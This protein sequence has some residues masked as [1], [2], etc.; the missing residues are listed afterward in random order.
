MKQIT[1]QSDQSARILIGQLQDGIFVIENEKMAFVNQAFAN[2]LSYEVNELIGRPFIELV[3]PED[4]ILIMERYLSRLAGEYVPAQYEIR[5]LTSQGSVIFCSL[6]IGLRSDES[7]QIS[8]IG[9]IRDV[10]LLKAEIAKLE[11]TK[12]DLESIFEQLPD[13][14]YRTNMQG[15]ITLISP[16]CFE[17]LGYRQEVM[18]GTLMADYYKTPEE[19]QKIVKAITDGKGKA[20]KVEAAFKHKDDSI[21]WISTSAAVRLDADNNPIFIE[22]VA[23]DISDRKR[24]EDQLTMLSRIDGLTGVYSRNYFM[25]RCDELFKVMR[26]YEHSA[27]MLMM[28]LDHFKNINDSYGHHVGDLALI[29]FTRVCQQEIRESDVLGRLGGEEYGLMMPETTV[30]NAQALAERIRMHTA[31]IEI[32][33]GKKIIKITVSIGLVELSTVAQTLDD[34]LRYAD[35]AMYKAKLKGRNQV[36]TFKA[37][38]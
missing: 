30:K 37:P 27:S 22:G 14:F 7:G 20:T 3:A 33:V 35:Q 12:T 34:A 31:A 4:H 25:D 38:A 18:L 2:M 29:A 9:S 23:R 19:R 5:L 11:A 21:V 28:D 6:N 8:T 24:M 36:V 13:V 15:I 16:S 17:I 1:W 26:C 10:T 32:P